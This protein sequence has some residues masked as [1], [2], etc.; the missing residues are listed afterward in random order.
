MIVAPSILSADPS[1]LDDEIKIFAEAGAQYIHLDVMDGVFVKRVTHFSPDFVKG[2]HTNL[3]KDT[4]LMVADPLRKIPLF[5][6]AGSDNITFHF[7]ACRGQTEIHEC[8]KLIHMLGKKAGLSIKP[9]TP[10]ESYL[11]FLDEID[12]ALI[13]SVEPGEG[14]QSFMKKSL[15]RIAWLAEKRKEGHHYLIEVDGGINL[16]TGRKCAEAGV[17]ILVSGTYIVRAEHPRERVKD[18]LAL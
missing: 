13:M 7:E 9:N 1:K 10:V 17:D 8:I 5:A 4:H 14:G 12:L 6:A 15:E 2:M 3:V 16:E 11:P 18:L